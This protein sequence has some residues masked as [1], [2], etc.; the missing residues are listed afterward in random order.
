MSFK[1]NPFKNLAMSDE[2][3]DAASI[4]KRAKN[5]EMQQSRKAE[6]IVRAKARADRRSRGEG[7]KIRPGSPMAKALARLSTKA[8]KK[9]GYT[10]GVVAHTQEFARIK[11]LPSRELDFDNVLD[12]T[13]IFRKEGGTMKLKPIQS[14]ALVEAATANGLFGIIKVGGGKTLITLLM[15]EAM[16]SKRAILIIPTQLK[17]Q[18]N[19]EIKEVYSPHFNLPLERIVRIMTYSDLSQAKNTDVLNELDPDLVILDEAQNLFRPSARTKRFRRFMRENPHCRLVALSG[20]MSGRSIMDYSP[21]LN[22]CLRKNSPVPDDTRELSLWAAALD[23]KPK[24]VVDPGVLRSLLHPEDEGNIRKAFRRRLTQTTGV[25]SSNDADIGVDLEIN[26]IQPKKG[27]PEAI[28]NALEEVN[29]TWEYNGEV[30][31]NPIS[32]W[33][34]CRQVS[35]GFYLRWVW[36]GG[37]GPTAEDNEWLEARSAWNKAVREKL[38]TSGT[39]MDSPLLLWNAADRWHR[40][41]NGEKFPEKTKFFPCDEW[42]PWSKVKGRY[43]PSP[44]TEAVWLDEGV[45][46]DA[47]ERAKKLVAEGRK[48]IVWYYDVAV[49]DLLEKKTGWGR[50][51]AGADA[52]GVKEDVIICSVNT[53]GTGKNL[54]YYNANVVLTLPPNGKDAEQ[55]FGRSHRDGQKQGVVSVWYYDHTDSLDQCMEDIVMDSY[56]IEDTQGGQIKVLHLDDGQVIEKKK[57]R[58][59]AEYDKMSERDREMR[60][61]QASLNDVA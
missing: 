2:P 11:D 7:P 1:N 57:T 41:K 32:L 47:I 12:I 24:K 5:K 59:K 49:G 38:K 19:R 25:V 48:T 52:S 54:Q 55:L 10:G 29:R 26:P 31:S 27:V 44:P 50:Y 22:R 56:F 14:A 9:S 53:Q 61:A 34:F 20:T 21:I 6:D 37:D 30:Y 15:P 40:K 13:C 4:L 35:S 16:D 42:L 36:P 43:K 46:D 33:R 18:L 58:I 23:V 45:V 60:F 3:R 17:K 39:G 28:K 51:G 8:A